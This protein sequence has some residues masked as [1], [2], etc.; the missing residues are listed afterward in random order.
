MMIILLLGK[1]TK[2]NKAI[3]FLDDFNINLLNYD[4]LPPT[5]EFLGSF[6]SLFLSPYSAA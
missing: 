4:N 2:E 3:F 6:I 1:L 5:Y